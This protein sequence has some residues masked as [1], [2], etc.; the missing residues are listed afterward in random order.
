MK[1]FSTMY[2]LAA[3]SRWGAWLLV[4]GLLW[5]AGTF[6]SFQHITSLALLG[7]ITAYTIVWTSQLHKLLPRLRAGT[8]VI[9]YDLL[10]CAVPVWVMGGLENP[11]LVFAL[12]VIVVPA[13]GRGWLNGM[14]VAT[15]FMTVDQVIL[16]ATSDTPIVLAQPDQQVAVII[17]TLLP[18]GIAALVSGSRDAWQRY[19]QRQ[20]RPVQR[21]SNVN[22]DFPAVRSMLESSGVDVPN[23]FG[24][25]AQN[26]PRVAAAWGSERAGQPTLE[27]RSSTTIRAAV[28]HYAPELKA[29]NV[30][31][32]LRL[33]DDEHVLPPQ[34]HAVI[35]RAI[36]VALDNV[37]LHA[38]AHLVQIELDVTPYQT[39]LRIADDGVG[40]LDGTAE[41]PGF[42]QIK[43]LRFRA[44]EL[45]GTLEVI[46]SPEHGV[47]VELSVPLVS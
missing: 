27:R 19:R 20:P 35:I 9:F 11:F 32:T 23:R 28:K 31:L 22:L 5:R 46:D 10:L 18:F 33:N 17:R 30:A 3:S 1:R 7:Y 47:V 41:P 40:L 37:L 39:Q 8:P 25:A 26:E 34:V 6:S 45:G 4:L 24:S 15:L 36:E 14:A 44:Q 16:W 21:P 2:V 29:A 43:R 38:R 13:A 42:H 12:S